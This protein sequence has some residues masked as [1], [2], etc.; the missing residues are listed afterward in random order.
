M[1]DREQAAMD[2]INNQVVEFLE[3]IGEVG[4]A[5]NPSPLV[6]LNTAARMLGDI[7]MGLHTE[8]KTRDDAFT[9]ALAVV[10][11]FA[12]RNSMLVQA[13]DRS[14]RLSCLIMSVLQVFHANTVEGLA[15]MMDCFFGGIRRFAW[16]NGKTVEDAAQAITDKIMEMARERDQMDAAEASTEGM[17]KQ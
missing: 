15:A 10:Y 1:S 17:T 7:L 13:E 12:N 3:K 4:T 16:E 11:T 5:L 14:D 8:Q 9:S 2:A 6:A